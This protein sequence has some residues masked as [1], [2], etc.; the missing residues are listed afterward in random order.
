[1]LP[2]NYSVIF[3]T[4]V[5]LWEF[6]NTSHLSVC[7]CVNKIYLLEQ[8]FGVKAVFRRIYQHQ[9]SEYNCIWSALTRTLLWLY[10][11]TRPWRGKHVT[12]AFLCPYSF[13][14]LEWCREVIYNSFGGLASLQGNRKWTRE[15]PNLIQKAELQ[16]PHS[17]IDGVWKTH[18]FLW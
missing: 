5:W 9:D 3:K 14:S 13:A 16:F 17:C 12:W 10:S 11:R 6:N 1:M 8:T 2:R 15:W 7:T 4:V 18:H